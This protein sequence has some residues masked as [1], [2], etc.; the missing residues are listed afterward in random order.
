[1][2]IAHA[3]IEHSL[4]PGSQ[5]ENYLE[6]AHRGLRVGVEKFV[7]GLGNSGRFDS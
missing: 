3:E 6:F 5:E 2:S 1:M 7:R 4:A